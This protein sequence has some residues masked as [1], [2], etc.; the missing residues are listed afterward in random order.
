M[1]VLLVKQPATSGSKILEPFSLT[2]F[3]FDVTTQE[4]HKHPVEWTQNP[5]ET[6]LEITDNAVVQ[7]DELTITGVITDT[8]IGLAIPFPERAQS[9]YET[10]LRLKD[11]R[12][13]VTVVTG[14]RVYQDMAITD[15]SV[16]RDPK[17]GQAVRPTVSFRKVIIVN[18]VTIPIPPEILD[19]PLQPGGASDVDAGKQ[20]TEDLGDVGTAAADATPE[21]DAVDIW[22][23]Q[24]LPALGADILG[25]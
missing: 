2:I 12:R 16:Q 1:A 21:G 19:P 17:N 18:S 11:D 4:Q 20:P 24:S 3:D 10:L 9:G 6:G 8:P 14:L 25:F 22:T 7:P 23:D 15:V 5:V 13:L